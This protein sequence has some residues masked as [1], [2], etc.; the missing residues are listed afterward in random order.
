MFN[1]EETKRAHK[2]TTV[3]R[4]VLLWNLI[5]IYT[6]ILAKQWYTRYTHN[7]HT[8]TCSLDFSCHFTV[9]ILSFFLSHIS[10]CRYLNMPFTY[11]GVCVCV[12]SWGT[13]VRERKKK[14]GGGRTESKPHNTCVLSRI[15]SRS[16]QLFSPACPQ[17]LV[18]S[19]NL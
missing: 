6:V 16:T 2:Y 7:K 12:C 8:H 17:T 9:S 4:V 19:E 13:S 5:D 11:L 15:R 10:S 14:G 3:L 1:K 18:S